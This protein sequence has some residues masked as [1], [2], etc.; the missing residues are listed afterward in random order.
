M[1]RIRSADGHF[2]IHQITSFIPEELRAMKKAVGG[3]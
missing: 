1:T 3:A 2:D